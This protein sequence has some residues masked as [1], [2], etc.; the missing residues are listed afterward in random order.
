MPLLQL[1]VWLIVLGVCVILARKFL[2]ESMQPIK[3]III[4][5]IVIIAVLITLSAF[6]ILDA[7]RGINTPRI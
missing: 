7:L 6:G 3:N 1:L 4:A 2:P 5:V